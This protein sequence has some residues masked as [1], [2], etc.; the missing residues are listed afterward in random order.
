ML[1]DEKLKAFAVRSGH[2]KNVHSHHFYFNMVLEV[3]STVIMQQNKRH[4]NY[5]GKVKLSIF[6]DDMIFRKP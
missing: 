1:N 6:A 2:D 5:K 4:P 3:L